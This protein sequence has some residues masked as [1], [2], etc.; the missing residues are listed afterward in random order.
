[1]LVYTINIVKY[2]FK[3]AKSVK[4]CKFI[5]SNFFEGGENHAVVELHFHCILYL[6]TFQ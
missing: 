3:C 4:L 5:M 1:M 6:G 2:N